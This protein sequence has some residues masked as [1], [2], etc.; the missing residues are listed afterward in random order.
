M[1][2]TS[3]CV[4]VCVCACA[5]ARARVCVCVCVCF[6]VCVCVECLKLLHAQCHAVGR[7]AHVCLTI[8]RDMT[9]VSYI[10]S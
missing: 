7:V 9:H 3:V 4:C 6:C 5:R 1:V 10:E 2:Y 8:N